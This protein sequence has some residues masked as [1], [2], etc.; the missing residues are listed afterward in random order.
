[1]PENSTRVYATQTIRI[2]KRARTPARYAYEWLTDYRSDDGRLSESR[3]KYRVLRMAKDRVVRIRVSEAKG[4]TPPIAIELIRL[5]PPNAWHV[6]QIDEQD[7]ATVDYKVTPIDRTNSR[8]ELRII[9]RWMSPKYPSRTEYE[10]STGVYWNRLVEAMEKR[11][12]SGK[13]ATG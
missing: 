3:P 2:V 12:R 4:S 10:A 6:D 5:R 7:L 11:Y 13:P 9:E 8:I 1:M